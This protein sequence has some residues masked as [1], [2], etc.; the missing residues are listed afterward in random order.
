MFDPKERLTQSISTAELERRW[1]LA[2]NVMEEHGVDY[3]L[4]RNDEEFMGG[5]VKWFSDFP[6]VIHTRTPL[7]SP[8]T[9]K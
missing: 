6:P 7:Y 3:L 8:M 4:M 2:R 5:Y 9:M 1:G